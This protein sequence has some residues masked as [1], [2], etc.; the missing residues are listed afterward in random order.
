M[1]GRKISSGKK[2]KTARY[3]L[4]TAGE[5]LKDGV[6][7]GVEAASILTPV[8]PREAAKWAFDRMEYDGWFE[9]TTPVN[10]EP[11]PNEKGV[12]ALSGLVELAGGGFLV[13][14]GVSIGAEGGSYLLVPIGLYAILEGRVRAQAADT[15]TSTLPVTLLSYGVKGIAKAARAVKEHVTERYDEVVERNKNTAK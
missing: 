13:I 5:L 8:V 11:V 10:G 3:V 2:N 7:I 12:A 14:S 4:E 1:A 6:A 15:Y 9:E